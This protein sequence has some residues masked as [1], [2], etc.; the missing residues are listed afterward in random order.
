MVKAARREPETIEVEVIELDRT[1]LI[2]APRS[3]HLRPS[4]GRSRWWAAAFLVPLVALGIALIPGDE[5]PPA[6]E[7]TIDY[8][9]LESLGEPVVATTSTTLRAVSDA[10]MSDSTFALIPT[11]GLDGFAG[12]AGPIEFG[13][14]WWVAGNPTLYSSQVSV[15]SST[16][17]VEWQVETVLDPGQGEW[18]RIDDLGTFGGAMMAVGTVGRIIGPEY[19]PA[20]A[21]NLTLWKSSDGTRWSPLQLAPEAATSYYS[22][23]VTAST[24]EVVINGWQ[25]AAFDLS[26]MESIPSELIPGLESGDLQLWNAYQGLQ[27]VAPPW[28]ELFWLPMEANARDGPLATLRSDN[29]VV[30]DQLSSAASVYATAAYDGGF[31][32]TSNSG[33]LMYSDNGLSWTLTDRFPNLGY[34]SFSDGLVAFD[35]RPRVPRLVIANESSLATIKMPTELTNERN[36]IELAAGPSGIVTTLQGPTEDVEPS[37]ELAGYLVRMDGEGL[38]IEE[39]SGEVRTVAFNTNGAITGVYVAETNAVQVESVEG[40]RTFD[41]PLEGL[42]ALRRTPPSARWDLALSSDGLVWALSQTGIRA[43]HVVP[44]GDTG[45]GFLIGARD[46]SGDFY[47]ENAITVYATGAVE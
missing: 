30:W 41:L 20:T 43:D 45:Q 22:L 32:G 21:G 40:D 39:P 26:T 16:D 42:Q 31:L 5:S 35:Y 8:P 38:Q 15:L 2:N 23:S 36:P 33:S 34:Q 44:L 7:A 11:R 47:Q 19:V 27:I 3:P 18:L 24:E 6:D 37:A 1:P 14:R 4:S 10:V 12:I 17:G 46:F 9:T 28:I 25:T 29:L 13:G